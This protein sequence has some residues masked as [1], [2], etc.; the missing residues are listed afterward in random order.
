M[1]SMRKRLGFTL[2]ELLVVIAIIAVLIALL[3]PAVQQAREAAR[4]TQCKNNL[5]QLGLAFMNYESTYSLF[6]APYYLVHG[7]GAVSSPGMPSTGDM[8]AIKT[9]NAAG[10]ANVHVWTEGL[11]SFIDQGNLYNSINF[12][13]PIGFGS[14]TG[15]PV[16]TVNLGGGAVANYAT[17]Q[18]FTLLQSANIA[19]F[20]CPSTPRSGGALTYTV[21]QWMQSS[22]TVPLWVTGSPLDYV[23]AG[24]ESPGNSLGGLSGQFDEILDSNFGQN[25]A[26]CSIAMITDGTS[27]TALLGECADMA[28]YWAGGKLLAPSGKSAASSDGISG[29]TSRRGGAWTDPQ[30][31]DIQWKGLVGAVT[32]NGPPVTSLNKTVDYVNGSMVNACNGYG[33]Y[34]FHVGGAH[35]VLADGGVRFVSQNTNTQT[36]AK[37]CVR[38]DGQVLGAF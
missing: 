6:P 36:I 29:G 28:N 12:S 23:A 10:D 3:L 8:S 20:Q 26:C 32:T 31:G 27:N 15:G 33:L 37:I 34:S 19:G 7:T 9:T 2:I 11:L 4:R 35:I 38:N 24:L 5:K 16:G 30:M 17:P 25:S 14:S 1:R 21:D 18:N 13:V 22:S